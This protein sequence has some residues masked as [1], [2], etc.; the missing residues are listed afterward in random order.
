MK[1]SRVLLRHVSEL[2]WNRTPPT[3]CKKPER[4][5]SLGSKLK[6]PAMHQGPSQMLSAMAAL[7]RID[8][9]LGL[10]PFPSIK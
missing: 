2:V 9:L 6:S 7:S 8:M 5:M 4:A 1:N 10:W 3:I